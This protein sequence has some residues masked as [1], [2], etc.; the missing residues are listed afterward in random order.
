MF[1]PRSTP[2]NNPCATGRA[3]RLDVCT[4]H[5]PCR[6]L[7]LFAGKMLVVC[8]AGWQGAR[9]C[10]LLQCTEPWWVRLA[11]AGG[12]SVPR[13]GAVLQSPGIAFGPW[14]KALSLLKEDDKTKLLKEQ[15]L[16]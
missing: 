13:A 6:G 12:W 16:Q 8:S 11:R 9:G 1:A 15:R 5:D 2:V 10:V 4:L 7:C 14:G 3:L